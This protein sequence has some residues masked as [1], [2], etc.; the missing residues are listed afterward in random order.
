MLTL[1][2]SDALHNN[3]TKTVITP[4]REDLSLSISIGGMAEAPSRGARDAI[5]GRRTVS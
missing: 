5:D 4:K 1:T 3:G 2:W